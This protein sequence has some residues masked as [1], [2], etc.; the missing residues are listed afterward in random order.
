MLFGLLSTF[1]K[2]LCVLSGLLTFP[3]LKGTFFTKNLINFRRLS[4][5]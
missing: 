4:S 1:H 3:L 2:H 5:K